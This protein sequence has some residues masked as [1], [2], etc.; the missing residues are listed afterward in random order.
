[1]AGPD[2]YAEITAS[3]VAQLQQG[4]RPWLR[5]WD[6]GAKLSPDGVDLPLRDNGT[7]YSGI[8]ALV[9]W[10][11]A[12]A[13]RYKAPTWMTFNQA[14]RHGGRVR[15]GERSETVVY[16]KTYDKRKRDPATKEEK[17]ERVGFLKRYRVFNVE[18]IE[19]LDERWHRSHAEI[20]PLN[21]D[22]RNAALDTFFASLGIDVRHDGAE[23]FYVL[24]DDYIQMPP[25]EL[26]HDA[27][28]YYATLAHESIHWTR[29]ASR[30]NRKFRGSYQVPYA[31]EELV[32]E[33]G[34]AFLSAELGIAPTIRE[35]HADYVGA[36][37]RVLEDDNKAIFRAAS[38]AAKAAAWIMSHGEVEALRVDMSRGA[39]ESA[40]ESAGAAEGTMPAWPDHGVPAGAVQGELFR[41]RPEDVTRLL[42]ARE[43]RRFVAEALAFRERAPLPDDGGAWRGEAARLLAVA[44]SID[45]A[46]PGVAAAIEAEAAVAAAGPADVVSAE[47]FIAD[48][49]DVTGR[50]VRMADLAESRQQTMGGGV[51]L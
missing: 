15:K 22:R 46:V 28:A 24:A 33:I 3:I 31:K 48:F 9:L 26:F 50:R 34:S 44:D 19:G 25:F 37:L 29:H 38:H 23:A 51:R 40:G 35:D 13:K 27:Q 39:K 11:A 32:A 4:I 18:Q 16:A 45:L 5:P 14:K 20:R 17:V 7:P 1:M 36:W 47:R 6:D 12:S 43:A 41:A 49:R 42:A 30:L 10:A 8:N 2:L 21:P